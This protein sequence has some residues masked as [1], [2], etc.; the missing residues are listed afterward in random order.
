MKE[1]LADILLDQID[2]G[3]MV[4]DLATRV[5]LWNEWLFQRT[6]IPCGRV[7]DRLVSEVF[8]RPAALDREKR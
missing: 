2:L 5:R 4:L 7:Q 1:Q 3:V 6:G 8:F